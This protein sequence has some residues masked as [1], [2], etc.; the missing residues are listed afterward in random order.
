MLRRLIK[1]IVPQ[2]VR[3]G[4][5]RIYY[6]GYKFNCNLCG[7]WVRTLF[8]S[9]SDLPIL[10]ELQVIGGFRAN[11]RCPVCQMGGR[12]RLVGYY[13]EHELLR[14]NRPERILHIAPERELTRLIRRDLV[15]V[16]Y[17]AADLHTEHYERGV[18]LVQADV[19]RLPWDRNSFDVVIC[20]H[21]LE[22]IPDDRKAMRELCRVMRPH[23]M[24]ILQVPIASKLSET[25]EDP[26]VR[27]E[28][29]RERRFG[30][31][32]HVRIYGL[33]YADRLQREGFDVRIFKP[34]ISWGPKVVEMLRLDPDECLFV[35]VKK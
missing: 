26:S 22:H 34:L 20:N 32:D 15:D 23:G 28:K 6:Y 2:N 18:A 4:L 11:D 29:E 14:N 5:R 10:H 19:T 3:I 30:Q 31:V 9:G 12:I 8:D 27:C 17:V 16:Q 35:A 33:D 1:K 21:V 13:L 24:A 7:A 25:I